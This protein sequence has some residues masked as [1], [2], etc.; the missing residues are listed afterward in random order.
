MRYL[1]GLLFDF[2]LSIYPVARKKD[3]GLF[4]STPKVRGVLVSKLGGHRCS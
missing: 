2:E 1:L 4:E 3:I